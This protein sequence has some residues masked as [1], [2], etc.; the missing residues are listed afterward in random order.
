LPPSLAGAA[1]ELNVG[2]NYLLSNISIQNTISVGLRWDVLRNVAMKVQYDHS[3][4]GAGSPGTLINRQPDFR[5]GS[6]MN[7]FSATLDFVL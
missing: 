1:T 5:P 3:R 6:A 4:I 7:L 2:L